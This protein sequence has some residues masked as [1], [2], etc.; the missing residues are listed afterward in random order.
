MVRTKY[1]R[2]GV[3]WRAI[4]YASPSGP[5][6]SVIPA[7]SVS[8]A[9]G[10]PVGQHNLAQLIAP[11]PKHMTQAPDVFAKPGTAVSIAP[12]ALLVRQGRI[13][14]SWVTLRVNN[15]VPVNTRRRLLQPQKRL[16]KNATTIPTQSRAV[17]VWMTAN[18]R[19]DITIQPTRSVSSVKASFV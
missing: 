12:C 5:T 1:P 15:A 6:M 14:P 7:C 10:V 16:A 8:L 11:C 13:R 9:R 4:V 19:V 3:A 18:A 17:A 2:V